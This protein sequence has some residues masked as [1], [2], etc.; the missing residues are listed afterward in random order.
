MCLLTNQTELAKIR[1]PVHCYKVISHVKDKMCD[2]TPDYVTPMRKSTITS[3]M[4]N[5]YVEFV[6]SECNNIIKP[7][8]EGI[9]TP[10][11]FRRYKNYIEDGLI[12]CFIDLSDAIE[13]MH[14]CKSNCTSQHIWKVEIPE[15]ASFAEGVFGYC[16]EE[17]FRPNK[18]RQIAANKIRF[19]KEITND[20]NEEKA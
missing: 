3:D 14:A 20:V 2:D 17:D 4:L 5:G 16:F 15:G 1:V 9:T 11:W 19:I 8:T 12:H 18:C 10:C 13:F 7:V 6:A